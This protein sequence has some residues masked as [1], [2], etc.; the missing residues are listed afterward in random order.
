MGLFSKQKTDSYEEPKK[1]R[2]AFDDA[3]DF[4]DDQGINYY[5]GEDEKTI[6]KLYKA[7]NTQKVI[8][9]YG[10]AFGEVQEALESLDKNTYKLCRAIIYQNFMLLRRIDELSEKVEALQS[11]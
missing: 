2:T 11:R 5:S 6:T 8:Y 1:T 3:Q 7:L 9:T 10:D 4:F